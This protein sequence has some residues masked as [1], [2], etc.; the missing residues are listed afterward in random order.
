MLNS[1]NCRSKVES[2]VF[3][4]GKGGLLKAAFSAFESGGIRLPY[5]ETKLKKLIYKNEDTHVFK[6]R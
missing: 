5:I 1:E 2:T 6:L 3:E 4:S